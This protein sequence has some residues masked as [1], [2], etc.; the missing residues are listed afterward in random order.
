M[1]NKKFYIGEDHRDRA[2][3]NKVIISNHLMDILAQGTELAQLDDEILISKFLTRI[4]ER[5]IHLTEVLINK[6]FL[7]GVSGGIAVQTKRFKEVWSRKDDWFQAA[8]AD[9][10]S[11]KASDNAPSD[12]DSAGIDVSLPA[13]K[14][15][16]R[17]QKL[18]AKQPITPEF[19]NLRTKPAVRSSLELAAMATTALG[20]ARPSTSEQVGGAFVMPPIDNTVPLSP[21]G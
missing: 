19:Q 12:C 10:G 17:D 1:H 8:V 21:N 5:V 3:N 9:A 14:R 18:R 2:K 11:E 7:N 6:V 15:R 16:R 13:P 4:R 20:I